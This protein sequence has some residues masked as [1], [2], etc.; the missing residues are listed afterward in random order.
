MRIPINL[1]SE[2]FRRDR[3]MLVGSV[4]C[5]LLLTALLGALIFLILA[6]RDRMRETRV[7]VNRLDQQLKAVVAEQAQLEETLRQPGN[8]AVLERSLLFNTLINRKSIRWTQI[9]NDLAGVLP[10]DVR[11][12]QVRLPQVNS[13]NEVT[14]D[15]IVG[16]REPG[17]V[18]SFLKRLDEAPMFGPNTLH[19][20]APPSQNDPLY[21]YRVSVTYAQK[22]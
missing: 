11:L 17:P 15:M 22:P 20:S 19:S 7:A 5:C 1:A 13:S 21:R 14:L 10:Y 8:A 12:I 9:F 6:E 2:P 16:A 4:A 18:I 3:P